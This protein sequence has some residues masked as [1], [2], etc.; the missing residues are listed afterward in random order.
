MEPARKTGTR[1]WAN[2][3]RNLYIGCRHDC[4]YCYARAN[5]LRFGQIK[6]VGQWKEMRLN[7]RAES[8]LTRKKA[9]RVIAQPRRIMFPSTHDLFPEHLDVVTAALKSLLEAS[10]LNQ[11]L[12]VTKP[13]HDVVKHL[14]GELLKYRRQIVFR[15]TIGSM[16]NDILAFW[17]PGA[18]TYDERYESL[19]TAYASGFE[20]SVSCEPYLD[21]RIYELVN[22][23]SLLVTDSIWIGKMNRISHRVNTDGWSSK[24]RSFLH[25]VF[26]AQSNEFIK[27][28]YRRLE[29]K[30]QVHWKDSIKKVLGLPEEE[31]G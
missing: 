23:V 26:D 9:A 30:P 17:E 19:W 10:S 22:A 16:N 24:E 18:P 1:E 31:I 5:A 28:L 13:H 25:R 20:T 8:E 11:V 27:D 14:C 4:R 6:S 2:D 29:D 15:F 7:K 12:I 21:N 3:T